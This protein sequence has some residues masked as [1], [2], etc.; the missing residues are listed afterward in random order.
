[1]VVCVRLPDL[2]VIVTVDVPVAAVALAERV[3]VV[4]LVAGFGLNA[5][6][7][8]VGKPEAEN[9]TFELNPFSG[10]IVTVLVPWL[11]CVIVRLP[12]LSETVKFGACVTVS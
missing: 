5:A 4:V 10:L 6:V 8:P 2:P 12:G 11:A 1:M 9:V 3:R 7:T